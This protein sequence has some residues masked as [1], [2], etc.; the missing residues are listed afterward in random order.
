MQ[1]SIRK[2]LRLPTSNLGRA[3][4][5]SVARPGQRDHHAALKPTLAARRNPSRPYHPKLWTVSMDNKP[6]V[7]LLDTLCQ[8]GRQPHQQAVFLSD[9]ADTL[10]SLQ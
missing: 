1:L 2:L 9:G 8:Q 7:R 6:R 10:H 5:N 4:L 3:R